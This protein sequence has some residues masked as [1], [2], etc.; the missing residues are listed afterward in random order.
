[1][2]QTS[3]QIC[4]VA[5]A[6]WLALSACAHANAITG[7]IDDPARAITLSYEAGQIVTLASIV[8]RDG[9]AAAA[10][11]REYFQRV[12]PIADPL[13]LSRDGIL[14]T[15]QTVTGNF[16]PGAFSFFSWPS[17][18]AE[19]Q[20]NSHEDWQDIK[21]LRPIA[22][23]ELRLYSVELSEDVDLIFS[24]DK[25]YSIAVAW[26]NPEHPESYDRYLDAIEPALTEMGARY[27]YKMRSPRFEQHATPGGDPGQVTFV[28]WQDPGD[29]D[30]FLAS[31]AFQAVYPTL[32]EG[33]TRFEVHLVAPVFPAQPPD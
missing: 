13:G 7:E 24:E 4:G 31:S 32:Q 28:E 10:A 30:R 14:A 21:T 12:G 18:E 1:M 25:A 9:D 16:Q 8:N 6:A 3:M 20:L 15:R 23:E 17:A 22:W 29:L 5:A 26:I 11:R 2:P 27:V 19:G 33:V